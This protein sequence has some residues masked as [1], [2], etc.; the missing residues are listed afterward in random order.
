MPITD[1]ISQR[2]QK[3][4]APLQVEVLNFI[5]FLIQKVEQNEYRAEARAWGDF[6]LAA[7]LRDME[8]DETSL[9]DISDLKIAF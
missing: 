8:D 7:A 5:E 1:Q 6:S 2:V 4:P 3:L 9:Y